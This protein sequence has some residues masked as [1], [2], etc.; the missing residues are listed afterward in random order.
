MTLQRTR[1]EDG[2]V[3]A[4]GQQQRVVVRQAVAVQH[5]LDVVLAGRHCV[6]NFA[7]DGGYVAAGDEHLVNQVRLG[8]MGEGKGR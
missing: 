7:H 3:C 2:A 8:R 1:R 5:A 6:G 4:R